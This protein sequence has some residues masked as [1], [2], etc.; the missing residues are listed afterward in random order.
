[1]TSLKNVYHIKIVYEQI[2]HRNIYWKQHEQVFKLLAC[3]DYR[4][5]VQ[6]MM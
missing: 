6:N 4:V 2:V 3:M 5:I 1:M